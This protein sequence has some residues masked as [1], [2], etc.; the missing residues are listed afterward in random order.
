MQIQLNKPAQVAGAGGVGASHTEGGPDN[1]LLKSLVSKYFGDDA[2]DD[3]EGAGGD[4]ADATKKTKP[5]GAATGRKA[6]QY[7]LANDEEVDG[8]EDDEDPEE[9]NANTK[10]GTSG[11]ASGKGSV[12]AQA[13]ESDDD[14]EFD[15]AGV[16]NLLADKDLIVEKPEGFDEEDLNETS[17]VVLLKHNI[18]RFKEEAFAEGEKSIQEYF[19]NTLDPRLIEAINFQTENPNMRPEEITRFLDGLVY[20]AAVEDFDPT[21]EADAKAIIRDYNLLHQTPTD[22]VE[23]EMIRKALDRHHGKR[24][25]AAKDLNIS[26]RTLYRKIKEYGLD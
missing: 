18:E 15:F 16:A 25:N 4:G 11:K 14:L 9:P 10:T 6:G 5:N 21:K 1:A 7:F 2:D 8:E 13:A 3:E 22:E 24:K 26:E 12:P 19:Q 20:Q 17:F 23:K